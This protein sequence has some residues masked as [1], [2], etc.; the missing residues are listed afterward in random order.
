M[1]RL[2]L[3]LLLLVPLA[4]ALPAHAGH[5]FPCGNITQIGW[6]CQLSSYPSTHYEYGIVYNSA[7]PHVVTCS[8][9]N[10]GMRITN[11][12]PYLV[13]SDNPTTSMYWGGFTFST[14]TLA[15]DDPACTNGTWRHRYW[16]INPDN[17]IKTSNSQGCYGSGLTIY[18]R[19][20]SETN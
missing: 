7:E 11:R 17:V 14:G 18:C 3:R 2:A 19:A 12:L 13:W 15:S 20:R 5:W 8:Y 6:S 10:V 4:M 9:W 16:W 1:K